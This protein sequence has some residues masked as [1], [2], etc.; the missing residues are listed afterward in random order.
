MGLAED[1]ARV[2]ARKK[3]TEAQAMQDK[4]QQLGPVRYPV[5][6]DAK[7][8]EEC[9]KA[10]LRITELQKEYINRML[11][12]TQLSRP[13]IVSSEQPKTLV[14]IPSFGGA[15]VQIAHIH[16]DEGFLGILE[17]FGL[18]VQPRSAFHNVTWQIRI[19]GEV[20]VKLPANAFMANT[21]ATP[22]HFPYMFGPNKTL[23]LYALNQG[24]SNVNVYALL[25]GWLEPIRVG[26]FAG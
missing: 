6:S 1:N 10:L 12:P 15:P 2:L 8:L 19:S 14:P 13:F 26:T 22:Y 24:T 4:M 20:Y 5:N 25:Q 11:I 21:L 18:D 3:C 23:S 7:T 17:H 16:V 9:C